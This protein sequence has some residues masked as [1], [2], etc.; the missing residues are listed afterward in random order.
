MSGKESKG[1]IKQLSP[2]DVYMLLP[3]TN[4]KECG[5]DNCMA[6]ATK[7]VN[8]EVSIDQCPPLLTKA[9]EKNYKKLKEMLKPAVKE[10]TVGVGDSAV[11]VGGKLVMYRHEFT[12]TNPTAI[13]I[14]VTDEMSDDEVLARVK[15]TQEFTFTYIGNELKLQMIAI[16]STSNDAEKFK[17]VV[18][19][20]AEN[21]N[22]PIIL[23]S[24]DAT[25]LE[26]GLMAIPKAKTSTVCRHQ[27]QLEGDGGTGDDV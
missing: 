24:F 11:N 14:D 19:K 20:V 15:K 23:C 5:E 22:L 3:K 27:G 13:A 4:C 10:V 2:I 26:S 7:V 16:R 21:T 25:I 1:G 12:Y 17:A 18:K 6:F 9:N 8:R